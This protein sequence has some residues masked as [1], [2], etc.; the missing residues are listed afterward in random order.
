[1]TFITS[2]EEFSKAAERL[3]LN[4]PMK[5]R[6]TV[7]KTLDSLCELKKEEEFLLSFYLTHM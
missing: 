6:N 4:D 2:W 5:V 1:M 3:Y 7:D